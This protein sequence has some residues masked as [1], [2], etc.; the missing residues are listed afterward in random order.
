M[1]KSLGVRQVNSTK[2]RVV[3]NLISFLNLEEELM[4]V[5]PGG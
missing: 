2:R 3:L 1:G 4:E 5:G